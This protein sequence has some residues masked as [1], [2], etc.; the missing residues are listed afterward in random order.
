MNLYCCLMSKYSMAKCPNSRSKFSITIQNVNSLQHLKFLFI[1][2][3]SC[4]FNTRWNHLVLTSTTMKSAKKIQIL[5]KKI[6]NFFFECSS[7]LKSSSKS[8]MFSVFSISTMSSTPSINL[9][10]MFVMFQ[11]HNIMCNFFVYN[12]LVIFLCRAIT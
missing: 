5:V 9:Y 3:C 10:S 2:Q 11:T 7:N 12:M 1:I 6:M 4:F 8:S